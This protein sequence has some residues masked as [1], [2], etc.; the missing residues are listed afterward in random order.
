MRKIRYGRREMANSR[1][2]PL[3]T[4]LVVGGCMERLAHKQKNFPIH[5]VLQ[6]AHYIFCPFLTDLVAS[7]VP[8]RTSVLK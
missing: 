3:H 4:R 7:E 6:A 1:S 8:R 2:E 5:V